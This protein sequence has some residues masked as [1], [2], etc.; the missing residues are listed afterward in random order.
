MRADTSLPTGAA[1]AAPPG[2][3]REF[4]GSFSANTGAVLGLAVVA[5]TTVVGIARCLVQ[6]R[7]M[8]GL[9]TP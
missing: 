9:M 1:P 7:A 6:R 4:W 5:L 3:L 8:R 2:P